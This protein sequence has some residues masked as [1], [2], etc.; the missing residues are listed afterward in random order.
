[1][2]SLDVKEKINGK[3]RPEK[4]GSCNKEKRKCLGEGMKNGIGTWKCTIYSSEK[5]D[6]IN[7]LE[8]PNTLHTVLTLKLWTNSTRVGYEELIPTLTL[9]LKGF[10]QTGHRKGF[11]VW[12]RKIK[13]Q[14]CPS[15]YCLSK[16]YWPIF[17]SN[18]L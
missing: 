8:V 7:I 18:L 2:K 13:H 10:L 5:K 3:W 6:H 9:F 17:Y 16:K 11:S 4:V 12:K 14:I 1:M 15:I